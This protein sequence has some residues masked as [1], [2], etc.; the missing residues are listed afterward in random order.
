MSNAMADLLTPN[1]HIVRSPINPYDLS[2]IVS[3]WPK[4]LDEFKATIYP[5]RFTMRPGSMDSPS[6]LTVGTSSWWKDTGDGQPVLEITCSSVV[7]AE[8]I[9][10]DYCN[11]Y[12]GA[13]G[14]TSGPGIFWVPGKIEDIKEVKEKYKALLAKAFLKQ[15]NLYT[16]LVRMADTL[17]ARTNGNPVAVGDD[18]RLAARELGLSERKDWMAEFKQQD[19]ER[20]P[21]CGYMVN[22]QFP[23][24]GN[25]KTVINAARAKELK[26]EFVK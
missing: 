1:R 23:V 21:A 12:L 17:W 3:I 24:C 14:D 6:L 26:L 9:V 18:M 20:C 25:C 4:P 16:I 2:T 19:L 22:S 10:K 13:N 8:S 7:V 15:Q 5:G 11:G